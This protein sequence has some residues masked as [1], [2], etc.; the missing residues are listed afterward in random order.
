MKFFKS[1]RWM[2]RTDALYYFDKNP[3]GITKLVG[4]VFKNGACGNFY[5][6]CLIQNNS[7][8][9]QFKLNIGNKSIFDN[10]KA[11]FWPK[12]L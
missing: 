1:N 8:L 12:C 3:P 5:N 6:P 11:T 9:L 4:M 10:K 2:S 7:T